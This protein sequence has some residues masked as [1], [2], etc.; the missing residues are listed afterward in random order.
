MERRRST[1]LQAKPKKDLCE[2]ENEFEE[3]LSKKQVADK[4]D[5]KP[6]LKAGN[7]ASVPGPEYVSAYEASIRKNIEE[8][9]EMLK[10]LKID[11]M[12]EEA[13][14]T[15]PESKANTTRF[16]R[17]AVKPA[18]PL[19]PSRRSLRISG[20]DPQGIELPPRPP[21]PEERPLKLGTETVQSANTGLS[22]PGEISESLADIAGRVTEQGR[23]GDGPCGSYAAALT[24]LALDTLAKVTP[25]RIASMAFSPLRQ[26]HVL[27]AG[28][29]RGVLGLWDVSR[30]GLGVHNLSA[31][32]GLIAGVSFSPVDG[33]R[34]FTSSYDGLCRALDLERQ[35][36]DQVY[37]PPDS[38]PD[39]FLNHHTHM[40]ENILLLGRSDGRLVQRDLRTPDSTS[41]RL[42]DRG[43]LRYL[44]VHPSREHCLAVV[45]RPNTVS[46][47][48]LRRVKGPRSALQRVTL[49]RTCASAI[50]SRH[51]GD[52]LVVPCA[53]DFIRI[54]DGVNRGALDASQTIRHNNQTGRWLTTFKPTWLPDSDELFVV[55]SM[56]QP[57]RVE[58]YDISGHV[59]HLLMGADLLTVCSTVAFHP[60]ERAIAAANS[61]GKVHL[62]R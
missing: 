51:S 62:F 14:P 50:I 53:D 25:L 15:V 22:E 46:L 11:A 58:V 17:K 30:G 20:R 44:N 52:R 56:L 55:G 33:A 12:K 42:S 38:Q 3:P 13:K 36:F 16:Y 2:I 6:V 8:R 26:K 9:M 61:S 32:T 21:T 47:W 60:N 39:L 49:P 43:G 27:A 59:H 4:L 18:K 24:D 48:D 23:S 28:D 10:M 29:K 37:A 1:R 41:L 35:Q 45:E 19:T 31:H 5:K 40:N 34:C 7:F 57:R 54:Y